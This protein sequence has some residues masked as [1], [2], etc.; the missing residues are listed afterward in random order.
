[1]RENGESFESG[2]SIENTSYG[3]EYYDEEDE[4]FMDHPSKFSKR[5]IVR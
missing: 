1:M 5:E 2:D 3:D 4:E